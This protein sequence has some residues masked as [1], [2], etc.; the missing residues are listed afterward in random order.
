MRILHIVAGMDPQAGGVTM[1]VNM[2]IIGLEELGMTNEVISLDDPDNDFIKRYPSVYGLGPARTAWRYSTL[3]KPWL[4]KNLYCYDAVIVHGLWQYHV[5]AICKIWKTITAIKPKLFV[6]PHG[7]LDPYFQKAKGRELKAAR[8][9]ILWKLIERKTV[10]NAD[11]ILFTCETERILS[12][13]SF[14]PYLPK[15][16]EVAGLGIEEPARLTPAMKVAFQEKCGNVN[17]EGCLLFISRIHPK[18]GVDLLINAYRELKQ[19]NQH[20]PKLVIA[21]P[22][23]ETDFGKSM[24][25]LAAN[26]TDILFTGMLE[27][28]AKWGAFYCCSAMILPSHQENFGFVVVEALACGRPVL[29][30]NQVNIWREVKAEQAGIVKEDTLEGTRQLLNDWGHLSELSR[31]EMA[32]KA[33]FV[34]EKY[35]SLKSASRK[36]KDIIQDVCD[37]DL[38]T[39]T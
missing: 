34:Y 37:T 3:L 36:L 35:F 5:Y 2:M 9:W 23:L 12:F 6:M 22:G 7:M 4:S 1:A 24:I 25:A 31:I 20:L 13:Q 19:V 33:K 14:K 8:N 21:G 11:C 16:T 32:N 39:L 15:R 38:D 10:N 28:D 26:T 30:S 17:A 29:I 27:G 18:K